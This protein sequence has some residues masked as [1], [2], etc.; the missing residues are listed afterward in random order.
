MASRAGAAGCS[1]TE[2]D[3]SWKPALRH[4]LDA[5]AGR[6]NEVFERETSG[7]LRDPW[8][9]R[10][11]YMALRNGWMSQ[12]AFWDRHSA[13]WKLFRSHTLKARVLRL[14]EAQYYGQA[15]Y[16]SCGFFFED[17][18]RIE[19]RNDIAYARKAISEVWQATGI[20]LQTQFVADLER[21][22]SSRSGATG[23]SLYRLLP[24]RPSGRA[25][26]AG[27]DDRRASGLSGRMLILL[28][29]GSSAPPHLPRWKRWAA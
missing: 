15:M 19:P 9:A 21:A 3:S 29:A 5:L 28:G 16:T 7:G 14:L 12:D 27:G 18:D 2:G 10:D 11:D 4:A 24:S 8:A 22:R 26:A 13:K 20:D 23:A 17:L 25:A 6:L 1:C